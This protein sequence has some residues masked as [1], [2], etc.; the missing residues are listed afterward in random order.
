VTVLDRPL[1]VVGEVEH[2]ATLPGTALADVIITTTSRCS[3]IELHGCLFVSYPGLTFALIVADNSTVYLGSRDGRVLVVRTEEPVSIR[4]PWLGA[5]A[6]ALHAERV[7]Q[8]HP[9]VRH[10][11]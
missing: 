7:L 11:T 9:S 5:L 8:A 10:V 6:L 2:L 3:A 1:I 4:S